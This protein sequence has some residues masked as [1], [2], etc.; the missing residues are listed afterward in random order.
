MMIDMNEDNNYNQVFS[1]R[2]KS[3]TISIINE[4]YEI[5]YSDKISNIKSRFSDQYHLQPA[6]TVL[7]EEPVL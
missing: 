3:L 6:I 1:K 2:T 4:L 5:P 7:C